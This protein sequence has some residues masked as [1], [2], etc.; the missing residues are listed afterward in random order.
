MTSYVPTEAPYGH[1][2]LAGTEEPDLHGML[3]EMGSWPRPGQLV[4]ARRRGLG[5]RSRAEPPQL[6]SV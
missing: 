1:R 6:W 3:A 2:R 4:A 5:V